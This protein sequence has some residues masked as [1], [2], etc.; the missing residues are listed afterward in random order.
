MAHASILNDYFVQCSVQTAVYSVGTIMLGRLWLCS[1]RWDRIRKFHSSLSYSAS[2]AWFDRFHAPTHHVR[3]HG[4]AQIDARTLRPAPGGTCCSPGVRG[5]RT[6]LTKRVRV[7]FFHISSSAVRPLAWLVQFPHG[8][9]TSSGAV[10]KAKDQTA[11]KTATALS[12]EEEM[13][14]HFVSAPCRALAVR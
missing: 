7:R 13:R 12:A 9:R 1:R 4:S 10:R 5:A 11:W 8:P 6:L 3:V 14:K 2:G